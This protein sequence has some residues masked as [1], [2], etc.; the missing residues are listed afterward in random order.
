MALLLVGLQDLSVRDIPLSNRL[1]FSVSLLQ[2]S[3]RE[4]LRIFDV[5][6]KLVHTSQLQAH[7]F[8]VT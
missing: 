8:E 1:S 5:I 2:I 3:A 4:N 7:L 6:I